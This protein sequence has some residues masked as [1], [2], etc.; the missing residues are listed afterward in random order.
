MTPECPFRL[1][2]L[3]LAGILAGMGTGAKYTGVIYAIA[4]F[5]A[6]VT[7]QCDFR[8]RLRSGASYGLGVLIGISVTGGYWLIVMTSEYGNPVFPLF[9]SIF[10]S[11][12]I[13]LSGEEPTRGFRSLTE[14]LF[15]PIIMTSEPMKVGHF[16]WRDIRLALGFMIM[17]VLGLSLAATVMGQRQPINAIAE[18]VLG[19]RPYS[20]SAF[21]MRLIVISSVA[22]YVLWLTMKPV[23]RYISGLEALVPLLLVAALGLFKVPLKGAAAASV[24]LFFA[25]IPFV[26]YKGYRPA[27]TGDF[28]F[29]QETGF[30]SYAHSLIVMTGFEGL[31]FVVPYFP[32]SARFVRLQATVNL[33][34]RRDQSGYDGMRKRARRVIAA[35]GGSIHV[36]FDAKSDEF[37]GPEP[38]N[39]DTDLAIFGLSRVEGSCHIIEGISGSREIT[40]CDAIRPNAE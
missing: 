33:S 22:A 29:F 26:E 19:V 2:W 38:A 32:P 10:P 12:L 18:S 17:V 31:S 20:R 5:I 15:A 6:G 14:L 11:D 37:S 9:G 36:L 24:L 1:R 34:E 25:C 4:L 23:F 30:S 8:H 28:F 40:L 35:H 13:N 7:V 21:T 16:F 3:I 27:L 39:T